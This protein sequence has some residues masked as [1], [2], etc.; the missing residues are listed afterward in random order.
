M[1]DCASFLVLKD[2]LGRFPPSVLSKQESSTQALLKQIQST[3]SFCDLYHPIK[4]MA[5]VISSSPSLEDLIGLQG[6]GGLV[7]S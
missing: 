5:R 3:V 1:H 2:P 7:S 6:P 4:K